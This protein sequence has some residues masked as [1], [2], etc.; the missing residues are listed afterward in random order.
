MWKKLLWTG[1]FE[2][3]GEAA[4]K[5]GEVLATK[6]TERFHPTI[7]VVEVERVEKPKRKRKSGKGSR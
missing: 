5:A 1:V 4:R 2:F 6:A 7:E 3:V